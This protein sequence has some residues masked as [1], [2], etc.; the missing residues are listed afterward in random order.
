MTVD[1]RRATT[2]DATALATVLCEMAVQYRQ[3]PLDHARLVGGT[4]MAREEARPIR[5]SRWPSSRARSAAW[6]R[7][8]SRIPASISSGLQFLKDL[9][10]R[11]KA[12]NAGVRRALISFLTGH[13]RRHGIGRIDLTTEDWNEGALRFYDRL[14]AE[15]HGQ[16]LF[17]RLSGEALEAVKP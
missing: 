4:E 5:I 10:V 16:K 7:W 11:D 1:V 8:R 15:R 3:P 14:G 12:R 2:D 17:L 9:F 6:R 13:C